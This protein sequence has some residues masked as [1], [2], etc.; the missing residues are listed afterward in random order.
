MPSPE[1]VPSGTTE[2]AASAGDLARRR[3]AD[4][5]IVASIF[6]LPAAALIALAVFGVK[7][8]AGAGSAGT[9]ITAV[10]LV[11]AATLIT[12]ASM[13]LG[14]ASS[15]LMLAAEHL[16]YRRTWR[17]SVAMAWRRKGGV[18]GAAALA[19]GVLFGV[20]AATGMVA[21]PVALVDIGWLTIIVT[22]LQLAAMLAAAAYVSLAPVIVVLEG[23]SSG[24]AVG[25]SLRLVR[26][27]TW[28]ALGAVFFVVLCL[29]MGGGFVTTVLVFI[30]SKLGFVGGLL[31]VVYFAAVVVGA[32]GFGCA[33]V[34]LLYLD[35]RVRAEAATG[36]ELAVQLRL[37]L[38]RMQRPVDVSA[39]MAPSFAELG[40]PRP[41][42]PPP[43]PP[44]PAPDPSWGPPEPAPRPYPPAPAPDPAWP[45][46][47]PRPVAPAARPSG[48][49]AW[50]P[51]RI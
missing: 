19:F 47:A 32:F 29:L 13:P 34:T 51:P 4:L 26:G 43:M 37:E 31:L 1:L 12:L 22:L 49:P 46:A 9:T 2:L 30:L 40:L 28:H 50:R 16:G 6:S 7:Q 33:V 36:E 11:I 24:E 27:F 3:M 42:P 14:L 15:F 5:V 20:N 48:P 39:P 8:A 10:L 41:P 25:R 35:L 17:E 44:A 18:V 38:P 21:T 45:P 23:R